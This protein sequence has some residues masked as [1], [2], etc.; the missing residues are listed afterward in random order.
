MG[1]VVKKVKIMSCNHHDALGSWCS[2]YCPYFTEK[3]TEAQAG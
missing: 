1:F 3:E 2:Y